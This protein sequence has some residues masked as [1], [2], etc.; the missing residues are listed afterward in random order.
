MRSDRGTAPDGLSVKSDRAG[1]RWATPIYPVMWWWFACCN[2]NPAFG[3]K[4]KKFPLK[5]M[6]LRSLSVPLPTWF[7]FRN[8]KSAKNYPG[9]YRIVQRPPYDCISRTR[10]HPIYFRWHDSIHV[11]WTKRG[12]AAPE[13]VSLVQNGCRNI[14]WRPVQKSTSLC[15]LISNDAD[16]H[17]WGCYLAIVCEPNRKHSVAQLNWYR[18]PFGWD[19]CCISKTHRHNVIAQNSRCQTCGK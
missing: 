2:W 8:C 7:T 16:S 12:L 1:S 11:F 4:N 15:L 3:L 19:G 10:S 5:S 13:F 14:G 18:R 17:Q 6:F 9:F